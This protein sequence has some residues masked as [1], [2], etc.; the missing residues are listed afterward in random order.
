VRVATLATNNASSQATL[1]S[2]FTIQLSVSSEEQQ[3]LSYLAKNNVKVSG[4][5]LA[6]RKNAQTDKQLTSAAESST[7]DSEFTSIMQTQL[8]AYQKSIESV[9][10]THPGP[11]GQQLLKNSDQSATLLLTQLQTH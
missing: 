6:L 1:N 9:L 5:T 8:T 2:A 4:K 10:A 7:Y 3:L 11:T